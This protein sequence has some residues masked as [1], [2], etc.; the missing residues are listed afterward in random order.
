MCRGQ[1]HTPPR[2]PLLSTYGSAIPATEKEAHEALHS[3]VFAAS[4]SW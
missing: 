3:D 4:K 2:L 1:T